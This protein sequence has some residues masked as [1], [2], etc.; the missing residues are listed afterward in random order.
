MI[1][2]F[3]WLGIL[4]SLAF[5]CMASACGG[6]A[7][8]PG[9]STGGTDA[10]V[11]FEVSVHSGSPTLGPL[12]NGLWTHYVAYDN[13]AGPP[14]MKQVS[15]FRD[16]TAPFGRFTSDGLGQQHY[17]DHVGD[18]A[19][20]AYDT[21]GNGV[22]IFFQDYS[23]FDAFCPPPAIFNADPDK[24]DGFA[25]YCNKHRWF[26]LV[27]TPRFTETKQSTPGSQFSNAK[28]FL[29]NFSIIEAGK[30]LASSSAIPDSDG[31]S[32][33]V[34]ALSVAGQTHTQTSP[35]T[36]GV[37]GFGTALSVDADQVG[38]KEAASWLADQ[39]AIQ[40]DGPVS[41]TLTFN[42]G[43]G[44]GSIWIAGGAAAGVSLRSFAAY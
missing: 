12:V 18:L 10:K 11:V 34:T 32:V 8:W 17:N 31:V 7:G 36:A 30:I 2:K 3:I 40:P 6:Y 15:T 42:D 25:G 9:L 1:R 13:T 33:R 28:G 37:Y 19:T 38:L 29:P 4:T 43:A 39:L 27:F 23:I 26:V 20:A 16:S 24:N 41:V 44:S 5:F 22:I 35:I 21:S 14:N